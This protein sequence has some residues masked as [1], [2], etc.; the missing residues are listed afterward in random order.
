MLQDSSQKPS[1]ISQTQDLAE[2]TQRWLRMGIDIPLVMAIITLVLFGLLMVYSASWK[3]SIQLGQ[4][5]A[6]MFIRQI[7]WVILGTF[8]AVLLSRI[9]YHRYGKLMLPALIITYGMLIT[10]LILRDTRLGADRTILFGSV[11][12]SELAKVVT[13]LYLSF[14]LNNHKP[15]LNNFSLG[16][17]PML[18]L[19]GLNAGLVLLQPDIS[20][21]AT[22]IVLG[23]I[24]FYLA[25][26]DMKKIVFVIIGVA[27]FGAIV[28][29]VSTT[30]RTRMMDYLN[31][32]QN[33][34]QASY[35]VQRSLEAVVKGGLFGVGIGRATTKFTGLP[36]APTDS[37]F[38]VII[39]ET[40]L[41]GALLVVGLFILILWRGLY[42]ANRAPDPLGRL[43]AAGLT[44]WI[45]M[46][47]VINMGVMVNLL[48]FAGNALPLISAGGSSLTTTLMSFGIILNVART[49][50]GV[51]PERRPASA[52]V[53]LRGWDRR[54]SVSRSGR[55]TNPGK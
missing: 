17:F 33:P 40:G 3:F 53:N 37:I 52:V 9:D 46:E 21:A 48:P 14:W 15:V 1:L 27:F 5:A 23:G 24:L 19:I 39:E 10:V 51:I 55:F 45:F 25:G 36:V 26:G 42:I 29:L 38:A 44:I 47:A 35:H 12:P 18:I 31:G 41:L 22:I 8:L 13:I 50:T 30:G 4:P 2:K 20:A 6:Y 7:V 28:V 32:L 54:G 34:V 11:Q 49:N 16:V 43:L